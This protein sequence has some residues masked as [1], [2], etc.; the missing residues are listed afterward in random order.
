MTRPRSVQARVGRALV[1]LAQA[2]LVDDE[3]RRRDPRRRGRRRLPAAI[4]PLRPS[5]PASRAGAA[6]EPLRDA[7]ERHA[8]R[9]RAGPHRRQAAARA[10]RCRPTR[11]GSRR[12]P[13]SPAGTAS[14]RWR[15][16]S[17]SPSASA[18]H[19]A[20]RLRAAADRRR[21]L[22]QRR[23]VGNLLGA[24][25]QVVRAGLDG[26][27]QPFRARGAQQRQRLARPRG[28]RCGSARGTRGRAR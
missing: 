16:R 6:R 21:A 10:T 4:D 14:D 25:R 17:M 28:G 22:E 15:S 7:L 23:A 8:A 27:R 18:R 2:A 1:A 3:R 5:R 11:A 26:D 9:R 12:R 13:S 19:S 20:S 24:E